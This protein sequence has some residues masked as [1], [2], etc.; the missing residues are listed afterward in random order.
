MGI[1]SKGVTGVFAAGGLALLSQAPEFAQQYRQR[2]GGAIDELRI[3]VADFDADA[4]KSQLS[5]EQALEQMLGS[6]TP[7]SRDR[8]ASMSRTI[9]RLDALAGQ[10][11]L[12]EKAHPVTRPLF[13]LQNPDQTVIKGAWEIFEPALP[14][15][16]PGA[17]Y[18]G[19]GAFLMMIMARTGI[20]SARAVATRRSRA[21]AK[22]GDKPGDVNI[23][24]AAEAA[25]RVQPLPLPALKPGFGPIPQ[26]Y[27]PVKII[28]KNK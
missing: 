16:L 13:V 5:R 27:P 12:M 2:L 22:A 20:A 6:P 25:A 14:F 1:I 11:A 19:V 26:K 15:T 3:V 18:G 10:Q 4:Q 24:T 28:E 21:A 9:S 8:G 7:F 17:V 23:E